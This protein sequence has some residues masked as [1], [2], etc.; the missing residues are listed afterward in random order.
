M[1]VKHLEK[2][3]MPGMRE[4]VVDQSGLV[5][6]RRMRVNLSGEMGQ[7]GGIL[8][9]TA[10]APSGQN[11]PACRKRPDRQRAPGQAGA[12]RILECPD[13]S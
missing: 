8:P 4:E 3:G 2:E 10:P 13:K 1:R 5:P 7:H 12:R 6:R 11:G 9:R